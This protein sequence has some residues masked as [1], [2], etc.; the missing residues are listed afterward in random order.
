MWPNAWL[1]K[2]I[3]PT[4]RKLGIQNI[5]FQIMRRSFSTHNLARDP[6][7]VQ[8]ILGH[9]KPDI[10]A[11]IYAQSQEKQMAALLNERWLLLGLSST[12]KVQ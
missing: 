8:A 7:S 1:K 12:G 6:K 10:S 4:A 5:T 9:S 2:R 3:M 11:T